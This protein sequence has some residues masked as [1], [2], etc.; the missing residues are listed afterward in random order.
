[1]LTSL[2]CSGAVLKMEES[3]RS[4]IINT[5]YFSLFN[6]EFIRTD[7]SESTLQKIRSNSM[8]LFLSPYWTVLIL[9]SLWHLLQVTVLL[10]VMKSTL[11]K[12]GNRDKS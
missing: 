11:L 3:A 5:I 6:E 7:S 9:T 10:L 8:H 4:C 12:N 1:M 2:S